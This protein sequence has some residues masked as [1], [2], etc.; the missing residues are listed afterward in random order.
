MALIPGIGFASSGRRIRHAAPTVHRVS[1][2]PRRRIYLW[3]FVR[4]AL[5]AQ[6]LLFATWNHSGYSYVGWVTGAAH[7]NVLMAVT[8]LA[9]L[10]AH[11]VVLRI[12]YVALGNAGIIGAAILLGVLLLAGSQ[13]GLIELDELTRHVEFWYFVVACLVSIG[14]GWAKYQQRISGQRDALKSPP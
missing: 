7:F 2:E 9:L 11:V 10:I 3:Q 5:F 8:G 12:A 14:V 4:G 1:P 6:F 13:L